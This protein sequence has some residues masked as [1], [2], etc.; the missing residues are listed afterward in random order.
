MQLKQALEMYQKHLLAYTTAHPITTFPAAT[1][2]DNTQS[3]SI[4][5]MQV[6]WSPKIIGVFKQTT[7][8]DGDSQLLRKW[9]VQV[10][11]AQLMHFKEDFS[12]ISRVFVKF[13]ELEV[14]QSPDEI[15]Q[16]ASATK[17]EVWENY[18]VDSNSDDENGLDVEDV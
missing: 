4:L 15:V 12:M 6:T 9:T 11:K 14:H 16:V 3:R 17:E 18:E 5:D 1:V 7:H 13:P 8:Q 2:V 10:T